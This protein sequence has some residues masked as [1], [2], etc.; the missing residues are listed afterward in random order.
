MQLD[1]VLNLLVYK[2]KN[3][4]FAFSILLSA[5]VF[6]QALDYEDMPCTVD[7]QGRITSTA[8]ITVPDPEDQTNFITGCT[9]PADQHKI[10]LYKIGLCTAPPTFTYNSPQNFSMCTIIFDD[11]NGREITVSKNIG[12]NI[13]NLS[14]PNN[15][16]YTHFLFVHSNTIRVKA[17]AEF[18]T[19][20]NHIN[21]TSGRFCWTISGG[22]KCGTSVGGDYDFDEYTIQTVDGAQGN[23]EGTPFN[24]NTQE[25]FTDSNYRKAS[26]LDDPNDVNFCPNGLAT[27]WVNIFY[28]NTPVIINDAT[29]GIRIG[30]N[31]SAGAD[32]RFEDDVNYRIDSINDAPFAYS[33]EAIQ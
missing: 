27:R 15:G 28:P 17:S 30:I 4:I 16:S 24:G 3:Y 29:R 5:N 20:R 7:G 33:V 14:R 13:P 18:T 22:S 32:M 10:T 31:I 25:Y 12:P 26:C 21:G 9:F 11:V 23:L 6:A 2:M 19:T 1:L 8:G